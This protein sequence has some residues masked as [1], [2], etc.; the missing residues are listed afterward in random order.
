MR[1]DVFG[2]TEEEILQAVALKHHTS[3]E[4]VRQNNQFI[5][6]DLWENYQSDTAEFKKLRLLVGHKPSIEEFLDYCSGKVNKKN[7]RLW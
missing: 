5:I 2:M 4:D 6:D 7:H 3:P 1:V